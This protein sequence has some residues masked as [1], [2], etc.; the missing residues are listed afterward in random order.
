MTDSAN[1]LKQRLEAAARQLGETPAT[2]PGVYGAPDPETG[3]RWNAGNLLGHVAEMI[4]FWLDQAR[5]VLAGRTELGRGVEGY[6]H[7]RQGIDAGATLEEAELRRRI[8]SAIKQ[9]GELLGGVS[10]ADLDRK[11]TYRSRDGERQATFGELLDELI[12]SHVEAHA[13]QLAELS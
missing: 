4:P 3:E 8:D 7:R 11:V 1:D 5:G 13:K 12:V 2:G 10:A 9:A 6:E